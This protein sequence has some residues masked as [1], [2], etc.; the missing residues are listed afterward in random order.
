MIEPCPDWLN[1]APFRIHVHNLICDTGLPWRLIAAHAGV[2]PRAIRALLHGR[3][4]GPIRH[5]HVSVARA[6]A[7]TSIDTIAAADHELADIRPLRQLLSDMHALGYSPQLL[8]AHLTDDDMA[9]LND[10]GTWLCTRA[11]AARVTA[12]YDLLTEPRAREASR[13]TPTTHRHHHVVCDQQ[14][15]RLDRKQ[16]PW[17]TDSSSNAAAR[18]S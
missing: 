2:A 11:T 1:P 13:V 18:S 8:Q 6:L 17:P 14:H 7:A 4:G 16:T 5:L 9:R 12:C 3:R 10:P 15:P